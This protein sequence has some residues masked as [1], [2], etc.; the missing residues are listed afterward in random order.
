MNYNWIL[1]NDSYFWEPLNEY[2]NSVN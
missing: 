2:Q 1:I